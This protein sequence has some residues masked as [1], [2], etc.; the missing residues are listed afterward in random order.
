MLQKGFEFDRRVFAYLKDNLMSAKARK[1]KGSDIVLS[2]EQ[3]Q[4]CDM[5]FNGDRDK[6]LS[7]LA[8][9]EESNKLGCCE[10][11]LT[12]EEEEVLD[13]NWDANR[14]GSAAENPK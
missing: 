7:V 4:L 6:L 3:E 11:F 5:F 2:K 13:K 8:K 12:P 9:E 10:L 14:D 1:S